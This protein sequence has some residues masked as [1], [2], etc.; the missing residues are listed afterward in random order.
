[1]PTLFSPLDYEPQ[2]PS[3]LHLVGRFESQYSKEF[4]KVRHDWLPE[5]REFLRD[6]TGLVINKRKRGTQINRDTNIG[7]VY[8]A[9]RNNSFLKLI[10]EKF[11]DLDFDEYSANQSLQLSMIDSKKYFT[12]HKTPEDE[13]LILEGYLEDYFEKYNLD[14]IVGELFKKNNDS[15]DIWG[16]YW[17]NDGHIEI[18]YLPLLLFSKLHR[19]SLEF[20]IVSTLIHELAHAYHHMGKD[21]EDKI[22]E[23]MWEAEKNITEGLAEYYSWRFVEDNKSAYPLMKVCYDEMFKCLGGPYI[24]FKEWL[25]KKYSRQ[26]INL[27]LQATRCK[28]VNKYSDFLKQLEDAKRLI[29]RM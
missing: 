15:L 4:E 2:N 7:F 11:P 16:T 28:G 10:D 24:I 29:T 26:T 5:L 3:I 19:V 12:S 25:E 17:P 20:C 8:K 6:E 14:K 21:R 23:S 9:D 18:Y 13:F 27:A 1:M 22:W